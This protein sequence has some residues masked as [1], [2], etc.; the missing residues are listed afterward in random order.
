MTIDKTMWVS[1][2]TDLPPYNLLIDLD[3]QASTSGRLV[4]VKVAEFA[5][6]I[7]IL[8]CPLAA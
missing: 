7:A 8:L 1:G 3:E 5:R 2:R 4:L 6:A